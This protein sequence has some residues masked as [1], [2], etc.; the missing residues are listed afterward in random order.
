MKKRIRLTEGDL[1]R[2]VKESVNRII[3][4]N[5]NPESPGLETW[6]TGSTSFD[7]DIPQII[8]FL[9]DLGWRLDTGLL[10][11]EGFEGG[12]RMF[13]VNDIRS[14]ISTLKKMRGNIY[15]TNVKTKTEREEW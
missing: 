15:I 10:G 13:A 12:N 2:I 11:V 3:N 6:G 7:K 4:E 8:N 9:T 5:D 14:C 1:H